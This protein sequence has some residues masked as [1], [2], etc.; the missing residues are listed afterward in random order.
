MPEGHTIHRLARDHQRW[1]AGQS[2]T[3]A[4]PQGR[5]EAGAQALSGRTLRGV[6]AY[7]KHLF[8]DF[9]R[10][11]ILH[12]HLGL[13]GRFRMRKRPAPQRGAPRMVLGND[14]REVRLSG[15]TA[16]EVLTRADANAIMA[17]LGPDPLRPRASGKRFVD[18][19][20]R[21]KR[22]AGALLLDQSVV[23]GIGNV[24][25][26]E[27]LFR[28][29]VHPAT[30]GHAIPRASWEALWRDTKALLA[31]GVTLNRIVTV[32]PEERGH[33]GPRQLVRGERVYVYRRRTCLRC[34]GPVE[35]LTIGQ[36]KAYAC[37]ACQPRVP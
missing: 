28:I 14:E 17:R 2:V 34:E 30:P 26:S 23:A 15:P 36:R 4:S 37:P 12:I 21:R 5:F 10:G 20:C 1:F 13:F 18:T 35:T 33:R 25:R 3:V 7:G 9:V 31:I 32:A 22:Q 6:D 19:V 29:G 24:Y 16:C 11:P 8:Y 27:L